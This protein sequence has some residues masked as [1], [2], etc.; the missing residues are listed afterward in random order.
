MPHLFPHPIRSLAQIPALAELEEVCEEFDVEITA[1][2]SVVRRLA[3]FLLEL[4]SASEDKLPDLFQLV[5]FLSDIDL[6]HSGNAEQTPAVRDAILSRIP[7]SE[8]F[9]WDICSEADSEVFRTDEVHLPIIPVTKLTLGTRIRRGIIDPFDAANDLRVGLYR[10]ER[11]PFYYRSALRRQHRDCEP[12]HALFFLQLLLETNVPSSQ[13]QPGWQNCQKIFAE[14]DPEELA[15]ALGESS[16]LRARIAYRLKAMRASCQNA[17]LWKVITVESGL[18]SMLA[19]L[20]KLL[21]FWA[22]YFRR[23]RWL[24]DLDAPNE[25]P[26][27][28]GC[29]LGG[30]LFRVEEF[31]RR[32]R[33]SDEDVTKFWDAVREKHVPLTI[34]SAHPLPEFPNAVTVAVG[35][36]VAVAVG[37]GQ[38]LLAVTPRLKLRRGAVASG[39]G[40]E[41]IHLQLPLSEEANPKLSTYV[42]DPAS[43]ATLVL[44]SAEVIP[45]AT[46]GISANAMPPGQSSAPVKGALHSCLVPLPGTCNLRRYPESENSDDLLLQ[47]RINC[48]RLLEVFPELVESAGLGIVKSYQIQILILGNV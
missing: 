39:F 32:K 46:P 29:R 30:D 40:G 4:P 12:L 21:P 15:L 8:C 10:L 38:T 36:E 2:G 43:L 27:V 11:N 1:F 18:S 25:S 16:Y 6:R 33:P 19:G 3:N 31:P 48:G 9:R 20:G 5:P 26:M 17:G 23:N 24:T 28:S 14:V 44:I 22:L 42:A 41:M 47:V 34:F 35:V 13:S 45:K 37:A 7:Y